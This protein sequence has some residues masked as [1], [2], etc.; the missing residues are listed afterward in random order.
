[1][2][3]CWVEHWWHESKHYLEYHKDVGVLPGF[4][5]QCK[6]VNACKKVAKSC[7]MPLSTKLHI[8][9]IAV[10]L[11]TERKKATIIK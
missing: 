2:R 7:L 6:I 11:K 10:I 5:F 3:Y 9:V 1:M 8:I 4:F